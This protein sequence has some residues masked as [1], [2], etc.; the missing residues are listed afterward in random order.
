MKKL[1]EYKD[2]EALDLLATII[3]PVARMLSD[4]DFASKCTNAPA[5]IVA[6]EALKTHKKELVEILAAFEQVPVELYHFN[7]LS[8]L[9]D[10]TK[11]FS[12]DEFMEFFTLQGQLKDRMSSGSA[13]GNTEE[14]E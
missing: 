6:R 5:I 8:L 10:V 2:E 9:V 14:K 11:L 1:S 4:K 7:V 12:D 3:D 13:T